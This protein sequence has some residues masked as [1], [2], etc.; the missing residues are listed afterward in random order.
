V[1]ANEAVSYARQAL[2][3]TVRGRNQTPE[4]VGDG[5]DRVI[6]KGA[7]E[8]G[9][10]LAGI[11]EKVIAGNDAP[12]DAHPEVKSPE[13]VKVGPTKFGDQL[14]GRAGDTGGDNARAQYAPAVGDVGQVVGVAR[15]CD[16]D[17]DVVFL[18]IGAYVVPISAQAIERA[19]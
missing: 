14:G 5:L 4:G 17:I 8:P 6:V 3:A 18:Q 13:R 12:V 11:A 9:P 15:H 16:Q 10:D 1:T 2:N 7:K 19:P